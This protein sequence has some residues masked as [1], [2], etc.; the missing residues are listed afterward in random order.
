[1]AE[2]NA[3]ISLDNRNRKRINLLK[4]IKEVLKLKELPLRIEMYDVSNLSGTN[5]VSAMLVVENGRIKKNLS[6]RFNLSDIDKQ[7]DVGATKETLRKRIEHNL[8]GGT[9]L[10]FLPDLIIADG[11]INQINAIKE[12][13]NEFKLKIK[14][15][16]LVKDEKHKTKAFLDENLKEKEVSDSLKLFL[17]NI[18]EETHNIAI[19]YHRKKREE[20]VQKSI[21]DEIKGIGNKRK[22][23]LYK[24]FKTIENMKKASIEDL[25]KIPGIT[26]K[27]AKDIKKINIKE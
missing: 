2:K 15:A 14:V 10:G 1:M 16:G 19:K 12:I 5:T 11:G 13:L 25:V 9:G 21:L 24:K 8:K 3:K 26:K 4:E 18:Q 22:Q 7:D 23:A 6:R 17:S 20:F 27:I